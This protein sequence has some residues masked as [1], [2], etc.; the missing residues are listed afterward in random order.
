[1]NDIAPSIRISREV[2]LITTDGARFPDTE[3]AKANAH[4]LIT[5]QVEK[6]MALLRPKPKDDD[7]SKFASGTGHIQ[8]TR[9]QI[10]EVRRAL[11]VVTAPLVKYAHSGRE[12]D[13]LTV[14][15]GWILR[16]AFDGSG[17]GPLGDAWN[18]LACISQDTFREYGS[19]YYATRESESKGGPL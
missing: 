14:S 4:Q 13:P 8:H 15:V 19:A 7:G 17:H 2:W 1:M 9:Q 6:A 18:R 10:E 16:A 3:F 11:W 5:H 12:V